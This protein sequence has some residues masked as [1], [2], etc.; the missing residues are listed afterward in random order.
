MLLS[1]IWVCD[2]LI[3]FVYVTRQEKKDNIPKSGI[4]NY[5]VKVYGPNKKILW[6]GQIKHKRDDGAFKLLAKVYEKIPVRHINHNTTSLENFVETI[7][8]IKQQ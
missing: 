2:Q 5:K 3:G 6:K 4:A 8:E 1:K 7:E